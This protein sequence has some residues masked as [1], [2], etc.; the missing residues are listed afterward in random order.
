MINQITY[1]PVAILK[2]NCISINE[3]KTSDEVYVSLKD[4]SYFYGRSENTFMHMKN[5]D[6]L[7]ASTPINE[8]FSQNM[9]LKLNQ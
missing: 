1:E 9:F 8:I 5:G 3:V 2:V 6:V 4:I 7:I